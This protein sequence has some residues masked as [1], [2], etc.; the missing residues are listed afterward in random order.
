MPGGHIDPQETIEQAA[1]R[2]IKEETGLRVKVGEL[3][4]AK[5]NFFYYEPT[6]EAYSEEYDT[7]CAPDSEIFARISLTTFPSTSVS[8]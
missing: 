1:V 3:L 5:E 4:F 8:R 2:E 6:D 7:W